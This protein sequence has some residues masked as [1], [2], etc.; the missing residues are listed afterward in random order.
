MFGLDRE[1]GDRCGVVDDGGELTI[2]TDAG[3]IMRTPTDE[4]S[5]MSRSTRGV[6]VMRPDKGQEIASVA[7]DGSRP[8]NPSAEG[9]GVGGGEDGDEPSVLVLLHGTA[10]RLTIVDF[11]N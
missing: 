8:E 2:V 5:C 7:Y 10:G 3:I 1:I 4:I 11:G 9:E 6:I